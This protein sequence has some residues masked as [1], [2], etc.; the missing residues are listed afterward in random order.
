VTEHS[1][2]APSS[3]ER[4]DACPGKKPTLDFETHSAV[5]LTPVERWKA[6]VLAP[7]RPLIAVMGCNANWPNVKRVFDLP[8]PWSVW[9]RH[10]KLI[11]AGYDLYELQGLRGPAQVW[12][13]DWCST[14]E[15]ASFAT[16][17]EFKKATVEECRDVIAA[18]LK[19]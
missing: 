14:R 16:V 8:G 3:V 2:F 17:R 6:D 9:Q 12:W 11:T 13:I 19:G 5:P 4:W 7:R 1:K 10:V 18:I 15:M